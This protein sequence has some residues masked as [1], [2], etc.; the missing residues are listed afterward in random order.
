MGERGEARKAPK[1]R[2]AEV[3]ALP[4]AVDWRTDSDCVSPIKDQGS[5][6][7]CWTFATVES[8]ETAWC[9]ARG[10]LPILA[11]QQI[12]DC[13][14]LDLG[15][16]DDAGCNGGWTYDGYDYLTEHRAMLD[17]DYAYTASETDGGCQYDFDNSSLVH[18]YSWKY[19]ARDVKSMKAAVATGPMAVSIQADQ[20]IFHAYTGGV[21]DSTEC[22]YATNHAVVVAGYGT[23]SDTGLEYWLVRNSWG[24]DWGDAGYAKIAITDGPVDSDG[25]LLGICGIGRRPLIPL[26]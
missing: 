13:V 11:P 25:N 26:V 9:L 7:S 20:D 24:T 18:L 4:G 23:D 1:I 16:T 6:G 2:P 21:I 15:Y 3:G 22:G 10:D 19:I 12:L 5:C 17:A 14:T 8:V